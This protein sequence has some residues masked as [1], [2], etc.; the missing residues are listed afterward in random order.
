MSSKNHQQAIQPA[1]I[2]WENDAPKSSQYQD[3]YFSRDNGLAETRYV[4]LEQNH[5]PQRWQ[6]ACASNVFTIVE[7]GF[8]T[9]LNFLSTWQLWKQCVDPKPDLTFV[10]VEKFPI[11]RSD[12][13]RCLNLWPELGELRQQLLAIYPDLL[14]GNHP[15]IFEQGR[16]QLNLILGDVSEDLGRYPFVADCWFLDGFAPDKNADMWQESLFDLM[17]RR[18][19]HNATFATFTAAG[20]VRRALAANGFNVER[21]K[22][23]GPKREMLRG[24]LQ[25]PPPAEYFPATLPGWACQYRQHRPSE[26]TDVIVI[27][28]GMAGITTAHALARSG[29]TVRILERQSQP[30]AGASGQ[31]QLAL[32]AKFPA[33]PNKEARFLAQCLSFSQRHFQMLQAQYPEL[34]FW[35]P[36]GLLQLAWNATEQHRLEKR[37]LHTTYPESLLRVVDANEG[38]QLC[39]ITVNAP[40][41]WF[42]RSGWLDPHE[43]ARALL[44]HPR[45][46]L[47]CNTEC[48][49]LD[50]TSDDSWLIAT[51][52]EEFTATHIV[53]ASAFDSAALQPDAAFPLK[54][55]RGQVTTI[56]SENLV[57]ARSVICGEGYLCPPHRSEHHFGATYD[58]IS[59]HGGVLEKDNQT[60]INTIRKWLPDWLAL[61]ALT[62]ATLIKG[63]AGMR[64]TTPDYFPIAGPI[65]QTQPMLTRFARLQHNANACKTLHGEYHSGLFI[66]VGHGSKGLVTI[67]ACAEM[68]CAQICGKPGIFN[69]EAISAVHP[70]R[71]LIRNLIKRQLK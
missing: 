7:T 27:G 45:I 47:H 16:V 26:K 35:H 39:G 48:Q 24:R 13:E 62:N 58:L 63:S 11:S 31:N 15:L 54:T 23:F 43:Y 8:G 14:K 25:T 9:G 64:C 30:M 10:S 17:Q 22:G 12:L 71:F 1:Q 55:L 50:R 4:F 3:I 21:I 59:K 52:S 28:A 53:L 65:H 29:L 5:L 57:A 38:A 33:L 69:D 49:K 51:P 6:N 2:Q 18:S 41:L 66:N 20:F 36:T 68:I 56:Q 44:S 61:E 32:Y 37:L 60:N 67:P 34:L 19:R 40:G 42:E 70:A 46:T